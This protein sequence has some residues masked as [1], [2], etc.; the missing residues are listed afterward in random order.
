MNLLIHP[1]R[2]ASGSH[3]HVTVVAA[4]VVAPVAPAAVVAPVRVF[5][6]D[7]Y[8]DPKI[9][10]RAGVDWTTIEKAL[11]LTK[12][13]LKVKDDHTNEVCFP[14]FAAGDYTLINT[15]AQYNKASKDTRFEKEYK[16]LKNTNIL[17]IL[18]LNPSSI[19][20]NKLILD[21]IKPLVLCNGRKWVLVIVDGGPYQCIKAIKKAH[22]GQYDWVIL[23]CGL[24]HEEMNMLKVVN[25]FMWRSVG[26]TLT[27]KLPCFAN[28]KITIHFF[29]MEVFRVDVKEHASMASIFTAAK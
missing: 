18:A 24:L 11:G 16:E 12:G 28:A 4:P 15:Q 27:S 10:F 20:A 1:T 3:I 6:K 7:T 9:T 22:P 21:H 23:R 5:K 13:A 25:N 8:A 29:K 17:A 19:E 2:Y 26:Q 14:P